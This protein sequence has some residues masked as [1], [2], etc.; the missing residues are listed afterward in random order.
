MRIVHKEKLT[1]TTSSG[2][3]SA[4]TS[5]QLHGLL[6]NIIVKP[7]TATTTYNIKIIDDDS[8]TVWERTSE[9]GAFS[10]QVMLPMRGVHTLTISNA[11]ADEAFT[12]LLKF[13]E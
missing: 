10:D 9:T 7:T 6:H 2:T 8:M 11:T 3:F 1:G 13:I 5:L 4:N 12:V